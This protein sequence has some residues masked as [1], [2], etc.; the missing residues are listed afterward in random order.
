ML[1]ALSINCNL[2]FSLKIYL[3]TKKT[4]YQVELKNLFAFSFFF[5]AFE[6]LISELLVI[7][8]LKSAFYC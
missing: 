4:N 2:I 6:I 8:L 1:L 3:I 7:F 5:W